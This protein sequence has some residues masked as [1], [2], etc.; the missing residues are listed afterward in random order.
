MDLGWLVA[1]PIAHRG[2][3]DR[4]RGIVE[5]TASAAAAAIARGF[6]IECDVQGTAD[7]EAVVFHDGALERLTL[8]HGRVADRTAAD[9]AATSLRDTA[10][11]IQPLT[12][13]LGEI[14]GRVPVVVEIK[15]AL[16][17][18]LRLTNRT[19]AAVRG[20]SG[21]LAFKSFDPAI[22]AHLRRHPDLAGTGIPLGQLAQA[23]Y[24]HPEWDHIPRKRKRELASLV[25]FE[26]SRPDFLSYRAGDLPHAAAHLCRTALG[27]PVIAW[28]VRS[29]ADVAP[30]RRWADQIVFE[31]FDPI[32]VT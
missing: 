13:F 10:D 21:P 17:G 26:S 20:Y 23:A 28:T 31:G 25:G 11:R 1:T 24:D 27:I 15:S 3:H 12:A 6:P 16:D 22:V 5:N 4:S 32:G 29:P 2:L 8:G 19:V 30:T 9:L 18:D 7:G 14:A